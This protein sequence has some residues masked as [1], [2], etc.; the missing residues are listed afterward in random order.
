MEEDRKHQSG[1]PESDPE[2]EARGEKR[3][4]K[5]RAHIPWD[6]P[7]MM[8][9]ELKL[10]AVAFAVMILFWIVMALKD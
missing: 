1:W 8:R 3:Y 9:K 2:T 4:N 10:A 5:L 7:K 6:N